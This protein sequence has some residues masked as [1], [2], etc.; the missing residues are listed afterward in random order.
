MMTVK[1][2]KKSKKNINM[3]IMM[4]AVLMIM[5]RLG[6][7]SLLCSSLLHRAD[8]KRLSYHHRSWCQ[9]MSSRML[10][11]IDSIARMCIT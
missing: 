10:C 6:A 1:K 9:K 8:G 4:V 3:N 2:N 7:D 5:S 11:V